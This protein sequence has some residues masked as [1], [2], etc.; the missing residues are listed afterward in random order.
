MTDFACQPRSRPPVSLA[1]AIVDPLPIDDLAG[2]T[3]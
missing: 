3:L 2:G 1:E